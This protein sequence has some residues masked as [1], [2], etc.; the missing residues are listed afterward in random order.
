V[1][2]NLL[3][4]TKIQFDQSTTINILIMEA[5]K[6][7]WILG[8]VLKEQGIRLYCGNW[9]AGTIWDELDHH[10]FNTQIEI[11]NY[12]YPRSK[13]N[14]ITWSTETRTRTA[15]RI[16]KHDLECGGWVKRFE[17]IDFGMKV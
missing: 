16:R 7:S 5:I 11:D 12:V 4:N 14:A 1:Y 6:Y 2:L 17:V 3:L 8:S 15:F 13:K 9:M 10:K